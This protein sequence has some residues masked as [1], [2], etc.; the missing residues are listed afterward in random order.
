[1]ADTFPTSHRTTTT[2][3]TTIVRP[4][5]YLD[6]IKTPIGIIKIA[7]I[8]LSLITFICAAS[9]NC[10]WFSNVGWGS[11]VSL[12]GFFIACT[13]FVFL[14]L[15]MRQ[16]IP[17]GIPMLLIELIIHA[18]WTFFFMV[19]GATLAATSSDYYNCRG[20]TGAGSFF[21]FV[22]MIVFGIDTFLI[23]R[24]WKSQKALPPTRP[25]QPAGVV[26]P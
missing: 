1:M 21:A 4:T 20:S 16:R 6:E 12:T 7:E 18:I 2:R 19:A 9:S 10:S 22:T 26:V 24:E 11:F 5:V 17:S 25:A 15:H 3:T 13:F 14:I 8:V 23:F